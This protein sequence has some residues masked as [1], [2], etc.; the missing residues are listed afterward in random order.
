MSSGYQV[1]S[2]EDVVAR[3]VAEVNQAH[4]TSFQLEG[5]LAGGFQSG[6]YRLRSP[7]GPAVLKWSPDSSWADQ[8]AR[9]A[10]SVSRVRSRGYPTPRWLAVGVSRGG[11]GYQ[12]Q[13]LVSGGTRERLTVDV[14]A[15]LIEV[16]ELQ[17]G[18]DPDPDR[19]WSG[20]VA[21]WYVRQWAGTTATVAAMGSGGR[22]LVEASN[23]LLARFDAPSSPAQDLVHGDFR[24]GNVL[25]D[26]EQVSGVVDIEALGSGS[27]A[28]DYATL[29]DHG[30]A[31]EDAVQLLVVAGVEAAGPAAIA[32]CLVHVLLDLVMFMSRR[33]PPID[34]A[35][36]NQRVHEL[37]ARMALID[38]MLLPRSRSRSVF[39]VHLQ[40][41]EHDTPITK[42]NT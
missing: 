16:L 35:H 22:S 7:A 4:G 26:G 29:L 32:H 14:A 30:E 41:R 38:R 12:I 34:V 39:E 19:S 20:Y 27:R 21:D 10:R 23:A 40:Y 1:P 15:S 25:F 17:A 42:E 18:L 5:R 11:Y 8:V 36:R 9:A 3:L 37:A 2:D 31:D 24:L 33:I 13:D 28:L 6:A